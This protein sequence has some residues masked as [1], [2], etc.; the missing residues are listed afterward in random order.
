[1]VDPGAV[2]SGTAALES[3]SERQ[4]AR[5]GE[6]CLP[7]MI[8]EESVHVNGDKRGCTARGWGLDEL[9]DEVGT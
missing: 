8:V 3:G 5:G 9:V 6:I 4:R 7:S 1:V 2:V